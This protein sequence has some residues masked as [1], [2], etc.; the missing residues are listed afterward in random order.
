MDRFCPRTPTTTRNLK[1]LLSMDIRV[2]RKI[3][4]LFLVSVLMKVD[5]VLVSSRIP[6]DLM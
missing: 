3:I 4:S 2:D 1:L 5:L 6:E